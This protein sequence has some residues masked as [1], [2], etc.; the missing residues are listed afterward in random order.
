MKDVYVI[1]CYLLLDVVVFLY[2]IVVKK[3]EGG[4]KPL[5]TYLLRY[6]YLPP[7]HLCNE[8]YWRPFRASPHQA[9]L[10]P[11]MIY[12]AVFNISNHL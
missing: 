5:I 12:N 6:V 11:N 1:D 2:S 9:E 7:T 10:L 4:G 3:G 8:S